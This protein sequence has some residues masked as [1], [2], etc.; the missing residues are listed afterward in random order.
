VNLK[1]TIKP[2]NEAKD[3]LADV[4]EHLQV[5]LASITERATDRT[6]GQLQMNDTRIAEV[7]D[8]IAEI[9]YDGIVAFD[10]TEPEYEPI[11]TLFEAFDQPTL[12]ELLVV[13]AT[14][15]DEVHALTAI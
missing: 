6:G 4:E 14:T 3:P 1:L 11:E 8:A 9:G 2:R 5:G 13:C 15:E 7:A 10:Q 12:V